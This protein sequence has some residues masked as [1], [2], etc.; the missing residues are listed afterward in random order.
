M[1]LSRI[2][3]LMITKLNKMSIV[4]FCPEYNRKPILP[5]CHRSINIS[6]LP[7]EILTII[8]WR[9]YLT[10]WYPVAIK[11]IPSTV[12]KQWYEILT[13]INTMV[14]PVV[15]ELCKYMLEQRIYNA[16]KLNKAIILEKTIAHHFPYFIN[17]SLPEK[18][19]PIVI[20]CAAY[21]KRTWQHM[22]MPTMA[23][24]DDHDINSHWNIIDGCII[25][26]STYNRCTS[27]L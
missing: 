22:R 12:C 18:N 1:Y 13:N 9:L 8:I 19:Y 3:V 2:R 25:H 6:D 15:N 17:N 5:L 11:T 10:M 23:D 27:E 16:L 20:F 26:S 21:N 4:L 7:S 24:I 14:V